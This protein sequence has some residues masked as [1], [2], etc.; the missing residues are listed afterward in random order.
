MAPV[1]AV[2]RVLSQFVEMGELHRRASETIVDLTGAE[3][4]F[5]TASC[6]AAISLAV[7][8]AITGNNLWAIE[9]LPDTG[10]LKNEVLIQTGHMVS[11]GAPVEQAIRTP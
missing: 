1:D 5:V 3:A 2:T 8:A 6:S 10:E 7:A 9:Q 11:Y 4:G